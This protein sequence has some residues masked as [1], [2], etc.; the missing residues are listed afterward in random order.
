MEEGFRASALPQER[1]VPL[2]PQCHAVQPDVF[3]ATVPC[4]CCAIGSPRC[5]PLSQP[6]PRLPAVAHYAATGRGA[7]S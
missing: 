1:T 2:R 5:S 7:G 6:D 4:G 3:P